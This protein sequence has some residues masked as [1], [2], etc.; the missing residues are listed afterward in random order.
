MT[1]SRGTVT[2][3]GTGGAGTPRLQASWTFPDRSDVSSVADTSGNGPT[4][5]APNG[6]TATDG[7]KSDGAV[8]LDGATQWLESERPVIRADQSYSVAAWVRL[9]AATMG[10]GMQLPPGWF[11][12]TAVSQGGPSPTELT[13]CPFYLGARQ[14]DEP[15]PD[16]STKTVLRWCLTVAPEDGSTTQRE[17]EWEKAWS[18]EPIEPTSLDEWTFLVGVVDTSTHTAELYVPAA[19]DHGSATLTDR[20]PYWEAN[21]P[22]LLGQA[23]WLGD[24]VDWWPGSIGPVQVYAGALTAADA[25]SLYTSG[26]LASG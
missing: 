10:A 23:L 9:D 15:Q 25:A 19:N 6:G 3:N 13:H 1:D 5:T 24:R 18:N 14:H 8:M 12:V 16:G 2:G 22:L 20:W 17:F 7:P 11:A 21:G 26:R 4:L